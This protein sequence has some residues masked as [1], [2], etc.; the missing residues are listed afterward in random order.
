MGNDFRVYEQ[1]QR[2]IVKYTRVKE[3]NRVVFR[4]ERGR[5]EEYFRQYFKFRKK[6]LCLERRSF[7]KVRGLVF[8]EKG[9]RRRVFLSKDY[10]GYQGFRVI[11]RVGVVKFNLFFDGDIDCMEDVQK[12]FFREGRRFS[13]KGIYNF[14][15]QSLQGKIIVLIQFLFYG[16]ICK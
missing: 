6:V 16:F 1:N 12:E 14:R 11:R 3:R 4:E 2:R 10:D 15:D 7:V 5:R 8:G 13:V 9:K